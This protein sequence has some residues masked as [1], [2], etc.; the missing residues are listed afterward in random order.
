MKRII[1]IVLALCVAFPLVAQQQRP[2]KPGKDVNIEELIPNL[3]NKQ[4]RQL[5]AITN[6]QHESLEAV[7]AELRPVRDSIHHY[8]DRYGDFSAKVNRFMEREASL[9]LRINK[10]H[11]RTKVKIDKVLTKEQ[12][13]A[14]KENLK[15][16]RPSGHKGHGKTH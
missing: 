6:E 9:Q 12:Y 14:F 4:K 15:K 5:E 13:R 10:I 11:Y 3:S 1:L 2:P 8:M 7:E 16:R